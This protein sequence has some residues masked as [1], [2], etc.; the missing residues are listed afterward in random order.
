MMFILLE[1]HTHKFCLVIHVL[2]GVK[3]HEICSLTAYIQDHCQEGQLRMGIPDKSEDKECSK[4]K[5]KKFIGFLYRTL[6]LLNPT[7][8]MC[9]RVLMG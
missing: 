7:V 1:Y 8:H 9:S 5:K 3:N 4:L 6:L 2:T